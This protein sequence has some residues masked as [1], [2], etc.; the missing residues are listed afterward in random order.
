MHA[1]YG[2]GVLFREVSSVRFRSV[3]IERKRFH[4]ISSSLFGGYAHYWNTCI[5]HYR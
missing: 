2:K 5:H 4:C 1:R 3:L